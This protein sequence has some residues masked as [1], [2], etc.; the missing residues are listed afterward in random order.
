VH[1]ILT[2]LIPLLFLMFVLP[3]MNATTKNGS[4]DSYLVYIGTYT[5]PTSKGIYAVRFD[6]AT[7]KATPL[8]LMAEAVNPSFL[9]IDRSQRFLYAVNEISEYKGQKSGSISAFSIDRKSGKLTLLNQVSSGGA[10]PCYLSLD[11]T[12][13][14]LMVANYDSGSVATL[15]VLEDGRL[16]EVSAKIQYSGHGFDPQRQEGPHP[17]DLDVSPDN[18]FALVADLGLDRV[19]TYRFDPAKGTLVANDPPFTKVTPGTGPRHLIFD[20]TGKFVY[21]INE[22]TSALSAFSYSAD[23]GV[24]RELA[25]PSTLQPGFKGTSFAA[26]IGVHPS[27]KFI[28]A[29]NRGDDSIATFAIDAASGVPRFVETVS[30]GGKTPRHFQIAPDGA[31]LFAGNQESNNIVIFK[32]DQSTGHLTPTGQALELSSPACV[33]FVSTK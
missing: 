11:Q 19:L 18:R 24:L 12:G 8:G 4:L 14:Y 20:R 22:L 5:G 7:G 21:V 2:S 9:A 6:A 10:G 23:T 30:S 3:V 29:S 31:Y 1:R 13:K 32:I 16:G 26:E 33:K 25:S 17:H 28:Y 15:P 27:G